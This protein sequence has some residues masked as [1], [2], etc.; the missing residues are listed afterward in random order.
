MNDG[1][2][3]QE[4]KVFERIES[5]LNAVHMQRSLDEITARGRR[6]RRRRR[7]LT[8]A[9]V[10][11]VLGVS[12]SAALALPGASAGQTPEAARKPVN[13]DMAGWSVHTGAD[14]A[15]T[16]TLRQ[17]LG[18]PRELQNTLA[19]AGVPAL[20]RDLTIGYPSAA[21]DQPYKPEQTLS[22]TDGVLSSQR[23]D[24]IPNETIITIHTTA[25]PRG[26]VLDITIGNAEF[27]AGKGGQAKGPV[28]SVG[29]GLLKGYPAQCSPSAS[30]VS[31]RK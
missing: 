12:L 2:R 30:P 11:G 28:R 1:V 23:S 20:V 5:T 10:A 17:M 6:L 21:C 13:V 18:D 7:T 29:M 24:D 4:Q 25:M 22:I 14:S 3:T 26:S 27:T 16:V 19:E 31:E 8:G 9:A 15:V